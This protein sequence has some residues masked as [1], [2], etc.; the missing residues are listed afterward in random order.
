MVVVSESM[1]TLSYHSLCF[2]AFGIHLVLCKLTAGFC[3]IERDGGGREGVGMGGVRSM[4]TVVTVETVR[5]WYSREGG[6]SL[7]LRCMWHVYTTYHVRFA[8]SEN[9]G[10]EAGTL[11]HV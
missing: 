9:G 4:G 1:M 11:N 7:G 2:G 3:G 6:R 5:G 10:G 8:M